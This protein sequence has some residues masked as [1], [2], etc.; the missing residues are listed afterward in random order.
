[1]TTRE[2]IR[3]TALRLFSEKGYADSSIRDI[4]KIVG[5]KESSLYFHFKNKQA[6]FDEL[7][8]NCSSGC[9]RVLAETTDTI[10]RM[11]YLTP[12]ILRGI[13][14]RFLTDFFLEEERRQFLC[15][16]LHEQGENPEMKR[17]FNQ[18]YYSEPLEMLREMFMIL[19][20]I[21]FIRRI[22]VSFLAESFYAPV[23]LSFLRHMTSPDGAE[24]FL[25]ECCG[26]FDKFLKEFRA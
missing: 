25:E 11:S 14:R 21:G 24:D 4:C 2:L 26:Y 13:Y 16:L 18:W 3:A 8:E 6:L 19:I 22:G 15:V 23:L 10:R 12:D 1:M 17:I 5:I 20:E 7:T 9:S